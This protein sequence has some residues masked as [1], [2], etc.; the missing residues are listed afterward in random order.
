MEEKKTIKISLST[1]FLI[2]AIIAICI[3]GYFIF[4][5][6]D[7]KTKESEKVSELNKQ[8]TS[9]ENTVNSLQEKI[10]TIS[11][12]SVSNEKNTNTN[13]NTNA[14]ASFSEEQVKKA[15]S[16]Y[17][18]LDANANCGTPLDTLKKNGRINYDLS[19]STVNTN[20]GE[21]TTNVKFSDYKKAMLNYVTESEFERNWTS[22]INLKEDSNGYLV[23]FQ[24]GGGLRV[25]TINSINK[26]DDLNYTAKTTSMV[27]NDN[28]TKSNENFT[29][30]VKTY[31][32]NCVIDSVK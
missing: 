2:I 10:E 31:N 14:N 19:K 6:N 24:G 21:V 8:I 7:D 13:V 16:N 11:N 29:F 15:F 18:E 4:K 5:L 1:F 9:F 22:K 23:H 12:T 32:G 27:E 30:T 25:Y 3:M 28:S 17:L 26:I 20:N